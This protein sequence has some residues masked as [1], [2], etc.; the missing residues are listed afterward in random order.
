MMIYM[1]WTLMMVVL[2][3]VWIVVPRSYVEMLVT[4]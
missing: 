1:I 4:A 2:L 3:L